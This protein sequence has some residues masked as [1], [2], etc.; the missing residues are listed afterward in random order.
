[1]D[2]WWS[3]SHELLLAQKL[4]KKTFSDAVAEF[5]KFVFFR[6]HTDTLMKVLKEKGIPLLVLSA[7][8]GDLID[9]VIAHQ[10]GDW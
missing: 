8:L 6:E 7:G 9:A 3:L 1:M 5:G 4:T 2:E 10:G